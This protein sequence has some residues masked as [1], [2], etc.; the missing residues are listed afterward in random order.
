MTTHQYAIFLASFSTINFYC[1]VHGASLYRELSGP[2]YALLRSMF[3]TAMVIFFVGFAAWILDNVV[4]DH[5]QN[6][7]LHGLWHVAAGLG[8]VRCLPSAPFRSLPF[9]SPAPV[10]SLFA[11]LSVMLTLC[12]P[13][14]LSFFLAALAQRLCQC[15][16]PSDHARS[17]SRCEAHLSW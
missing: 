14:F 13:F 5:L 7:G 16:T 6:S 9:S 11:L 1:M 17:P 2:R 8:G 12:P 3:V 4:C 15:T 10:L